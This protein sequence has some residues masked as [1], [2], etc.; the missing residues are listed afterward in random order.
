MLALLAFALPNP[1]TDVA[2]A[3][4]RRTDWVESNVAVVNDPSARIDLDGLY[5]RF[6]KKQ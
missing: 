5:A 6:P 1:M 2:L 4:M 3:H